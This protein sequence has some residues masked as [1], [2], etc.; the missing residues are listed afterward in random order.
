[1]HLKIRIM[2]G[3]FKY[4]SISLFLAVITEVGAQDATLILKNARIC[5]MDESRPAAEAVAIRGDRILKVGTDAEII[6]HQGRDTRVIDAKGAFVMPGLIEGHG[7]I[8]GMGASLIELNLMK[9]ANWEEVLTM[10]GQ[11]VK[12]AKPGDWIVGRG[13]HQEKWNRKPAP[14][15]LGYPYHQSL[16]N[17]SP[18]NPVMLTHASGHST[19]ANAL[20]LRLAGITDQTPSPKGGDIVRDPTGRMVGVLEETAQGLVTRAYGQWM[21][22]KSEAERKAEWQRSIRLAEEECLR[23]GITT[24]VDAG[25]SFSQ[26]EWMRELA[27]QDRLL[28]RHWVMVRSGIESIRRQAGLF[29]VMNEGKGRLTVN[30]IKV[31]LDGALGSYGAWL[32][33]PY[34]DRAGFMG[35]NTFSVPELRDIARLAWD[36]NIQLCVHAIGDRANRE[37][38]D[39]FAEQVRRDRN[40]DHR[41]RIEHAQHVH[42]SDI[43]RFREWKVI[44]SMQGI[45][46][47]SDAPYVPKRLGPERAATESYMWRSFID[48]GVLVNNG[49]DVPVE[50]IDPFANLHASV[51]RQTADGSAFYPEQ[52]MTRYEALRSYTLDNA[53]AMFQE[54]DKGSIVAGKLADIV[55]MSEDL[56]NC[57]DD[58][59]RSARVR[60]TILGGAVAYSKE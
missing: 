47:T 46:C 14:A 48:A 60:M 16:D 44:A 22:L 58:R 39:I 36:R 59:I 56:L 37:T 53:K 25:S 23:Y 3:W 35:Q 29:P 13:W 31:S 41:W 7:H 10:V 5:T 4:L 55:V 8:H 26:V 49:T 40:K 20:A 33:E 43:P 6:K 57:P 42:P 17:V 54:A 18:A 27:A 34:T 52:R 28:V 9:A 2:T 24:F 12:K 1:M 51:T 50:D 21:S 19:Y 30:A 11:A 15:H 32:L 38:L 45:H